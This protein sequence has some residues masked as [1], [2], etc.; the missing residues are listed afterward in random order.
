MKKIRMPLFY[1]AFSA[2]CFA[3]CTSKEQE[4]T[5]ETPVLRELIPVDSATQYIANYAP[6]AGTAVATIDT[7]INGKR[8]KLVVESPNSRAIWFSLKQLKGFVEKL[9][10]EKGDGVRF[11]FATYNKNYPNGAV[12]KPKQEYWGH[13]TLV[14][15]STKRDSIGKRIIHQDYYVPAGGF[16][17]KDFKKGFIVGN[18]PENRG[19]MCPPPKA[20]D[21]VGAEL[22][23]PSKPVH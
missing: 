13:N 22:I 7:V 15:V 16:K 12:D 21:S 6:H 9:E 14:M 5:S 8:T 10:K 4:T 11:Y 17:P 20:C 2:I 19:E 18:P 1:L 23:D 3:A